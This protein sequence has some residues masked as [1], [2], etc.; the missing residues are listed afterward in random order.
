MARL[1]DGEAAAGSLVGQDFDF[2]SLISFA[3][4]FPLAR[5]KANCFRSVV[6]YEASVAEAIEHVFESPDEVVWVEQPS[7]IACNADKTA[8][9]WRCFTLAR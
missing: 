6:R 5:F 4:N 9:C 1:P 7:A 8:T 2:S 3:R